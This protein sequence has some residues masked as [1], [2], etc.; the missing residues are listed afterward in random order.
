LGKSGPAE[1]ISCGAA[2]LATVLS[3]QQGDKVSEQEV[4]AGL[5]HYTTP[6]RQRGGFSM[7]DLKRYAQSRA[8]IAEGFGDMTIG[9]LEAFGPAIVRMTANGQHRFVVFLGGQGEQIHV[10][11]PA[12]GN[13]YMGLRDH[14]GQSRA[15][16]N[17]HDAKLGCCTRCRFVHQEAERFL[18]HLDSR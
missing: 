9:D 11:D 4:I 3:Y 12:V 16:N 18:E 6:L 17:A 5:L 10:A 7:L 8:Y 2:A 14:V 13:G 15:Q 1:L